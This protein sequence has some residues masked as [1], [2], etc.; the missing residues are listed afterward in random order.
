[1]VFLMKDL[2]LSTA[3]ERFQCYNTT[4]S[5]SGAYS[6]AQA[7]LSERLGR[8]FPILRVLVI[9]QIFALNIPVKPR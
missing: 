2:Q 7:K 1:M 6:G 3:G 9:R 4:A 8:K 5:M